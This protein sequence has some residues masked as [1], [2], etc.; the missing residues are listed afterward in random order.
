VLAAVQAQYTDQPLLVPEQFALGGEQFLRAYDAAELL[1]DRG[2]GLKV[3]LRYSLTASGSAQHMGFYDYGRVYYNAS[4][5]PGQG[6]ASAGAGP[7][8][9][10]SRDNAARGRTGG[11]AHRVIPAS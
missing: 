4:S 11:D 7:R 8:L 6:A 2:F 3:E 10:Q 9:T 5:L 1:G